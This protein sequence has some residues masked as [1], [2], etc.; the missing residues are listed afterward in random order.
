MRQTYVNP[1]AAEVTGLPQEAFI[2]RTLTEM[3][4]PPDQI[5]FWETHINEVFRT[6]REG[7]MT[8]DYET[9]HGRR[10]YEARLVAERDPD[11]QVI[12]SVLVV[13]RDVTREERAL[14]ELRASEAR[15]RCVFEHTTDAMFIADFAGVILHAN[16]A[17]A[18]VT[19]RRLSALVGT[20]VNDLFVDAVRERLD[21]DAVLGGTILA[22]RVTVRGVA[23][24]PALTLTMQP[25]RTDD[26]TI[27]GFFGC[28]R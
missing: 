27:S 14:V 3:G 11:T 5:L 20:P 17:L 28:L 24:A 22:G 7:R 19:R 13:S 4:Y 26:A 23:D 21:Y 8:F 12:E 9:P 16:P 18:T 6:G 10:L 25:L 2:G 1:R 15:F